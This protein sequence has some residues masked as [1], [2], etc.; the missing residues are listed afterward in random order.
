MSYYAPQEPPLQQGQDELPEQNES[1]PQDSLH[2][3]VAYLPAIMFL[4][5]LLESEFSKLFKLIFFIIFKFR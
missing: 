1:V 3:G 4:I 2:S 5:S